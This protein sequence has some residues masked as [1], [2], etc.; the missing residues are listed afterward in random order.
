[1]GK[2]PL[3]PISNVDE[4]GCPGNLAD[5]AMLDKIDRLFACN[6]GDY[7]DL[8]QIVVVGDQSS[9][10]SSVLEGLTDLPFPRDSGLCT[11]FATQIT[12]RR[13]E[14]Q[15]IA[16]SIVPGK[17]SSLEHAE[18][19]RKW[20]KVMETLDQKSFADIMHEDDDLFPSKT[21]SDD[22]FCI[23]VTGP[24]QE[25]LS[26]IDVPGIFKRTTQ[27]VTNKSDMQMVKSMVQ[28][29]M[30]NP[31]SVIL[32]VIPANVDIATQEILEMAEEVDPEGQR[33]LGVLTKP[34]LVDKGAEKAVMSLIEGQR[35]QLSL[36]W[37]LLRNLGQQ[38]SSDRTMDRHALEKSFF[39]SQAPW[40]TLDKDKVGIPALKICLREILAVHTRREF[41]KVKAEL[42]KKLKICRT[43]HS[44]M[45]E[46]RDTPADQSRYLI[47]IA[48]RF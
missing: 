36:G 9:G 26:V 30:E 27:G 3:K 38:E 15:R 28:G 45:G 25:H 14:V 11:R 37:M 32:A 29:F 41:P 31:R 34:D 22:V 42:N 17:Y 46:S 24:K 10:K 47:G 12:F 40:N 8:P 48:T 43:A 20:T 21:F 7:V 35:H 23:K 5:P 18:H 44:N 13:S 1:M 6:V 33:T 16:V 2:K 4:C 19:V 39:V